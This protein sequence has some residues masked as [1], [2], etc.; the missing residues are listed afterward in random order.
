MC[1]KGKEREIDVGTGEVHGDKAK[2]VR[3]MF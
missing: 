2:A 1:V 3:Y